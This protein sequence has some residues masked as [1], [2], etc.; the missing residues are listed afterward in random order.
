MLQQ[1]EEGRAG[2]RGRWPRPGVF[3][4]RIGEEGSLGRLLRG[5]TGGGRRRIAI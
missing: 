5:T 2:G 1:G 3:A 4:R